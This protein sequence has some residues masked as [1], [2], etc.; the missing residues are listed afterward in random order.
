MNPKGSVVIPSAGLSSPAQRIS[1]VVFERE[2]G[3]RLVHRKEFPRR[4]KLGTLDV[5]PEQVTKVDLYVHVPM[6]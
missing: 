4:P 2:G 1:G 5:Y 6:I 3:S